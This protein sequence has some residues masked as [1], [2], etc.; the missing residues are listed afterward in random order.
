MQ[1]LND[2]IQGLTAAKTFEEMPTLDFSDLEARATANLSKSHPVITGEDIHRKMASAMFGLTACDVRE[3]HRQ[4]A[5]NENFRQ[6]YSYKGGSID[7]LVYPNEPTHCRSCLKPLDPTNP[8]VYNT[9][10]DCGDY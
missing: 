4:V 6:I 8:Q 7:N 9:C 5:K 1:N 2:F 3:K 10:T